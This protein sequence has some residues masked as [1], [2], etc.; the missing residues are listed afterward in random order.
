MARQR[1]AVEQERQAEA[2]MYVNKVEQWG[3]DSELK[4]EKVKDLLAGIEANEEN[5][6]VAARV[7][8]ESAWKKQLLGDSSNP[9][10][11][12]VTVG[13]EAVDVPATWEWLGED[14]KWAKYGASEQTLLQKLLADGGGSVTFPR[15]DQSYKIDMSITTGGKTIALEVDGSDSIENVKAKIQDKGGIPPDQ[16]RLTLAGI[17]LQDGR[18]LADYKSRRSRGSS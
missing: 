10:T 8:Q 18:T 6:R 7:D 9:P 15:A 12:D 14:G 16:Q 1:G 3:R 13:A 4:L 2:T 17:A 11:L 5:V